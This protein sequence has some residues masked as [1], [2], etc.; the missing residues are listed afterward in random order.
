MVSMPEIWEEDRDNF[1]KMVIICERNHQVQTFSLGIHIIII[2]IIG[3]LGCRCQ[4]TCQNRI[5]KFENLS[6]FFPSR[7]PPLDWK[8][9]FKKAAVQIFILKPSWV[10]NV[11]IVP[12]ISTSWYGLGLQ[13]LLGTPSSFFIHENCGDDMWWF[14]MLSSTFG[15][16]PNHF[17]E[18]CI[19]L[20]LYSS[21][22]NFS[23][24][25]VEVF[26]W[27]ECRMQAILS[28]PRSYSHTCLSWNMPECQKKPLKPHLISI[29][30]SK[31]NETFIPKN[32]M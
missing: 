22:T 2:L 29:S 8:S 20:N 13:N 19:Q 25:A 9:V 28:L 12:R 32:A 18:S 24:S 10:S 1:P 26:G 14:P 31:A 27:Q 4:L 23:K 5:E 30:A 3:F 15:Q 11:Y 6:H 16:S 21:L 17:H 7:L